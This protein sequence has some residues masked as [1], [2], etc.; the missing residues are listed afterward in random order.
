MKKKHEISLISAT[1][2][3]A[4]CMVGSGW[5]FSSQL[6]AQQAG[7]YS[8]LA[9]VVAA[10]FA[11]IV[12]L[13]F[14][15][16]VQTYPVRG[17]TTRISSLT[18]NSLFGIPFS[19]ANWFGVLVSVATEAQATTQ[20]LASASGS[21][22][23]IKAGDLT[24]LGKGVALS[25]LFLYLVINFYGIKLLARVNNVV[26]FLKVM[27]PTVIIVSFLVV[28][29]T[30]KGAFPVV[31]DHHTFG[32]VLPAVVG[33]GLVYAFNG[34]QTAV[35][36]CSEIKNPTRNVPLS[37][38]LSIFIVLCVYLGLQFAFMEAVRSS[39]LAQGW[40]HLSFNSPLLDLSVILGLH[41]LSLLLVVDSVTSPSG[42]GY[43]YLGASGRM[44]T[45]MAEEGQAPKWLS[46]SNPT[47]NFSRRALLI[48]WGIAAIILYFSTG[49]TALM[50]IVTGLNIIGYLAA[51]I[52]MAAITPK[53]RWAGVIVFLLISLFLSSVGQHGLLL[54]NSTI[55]LLILAYVV[56]HRHYGIKNILI[57]ISP[58]VIYFWC[59]LF[60]FYVIG[61]VSILL[62]FLMSHPKYVTCL[63]KM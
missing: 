63:N 60:P 17:A 37:I 28:A 59:L 18:H 32:N 31:P 52:S 46:V 35:S 26:T 42:T 8:F 5:L 25:I 48:N 51:P 55:T 19:F 53:L 54:I 12:G 14:A 27:T 40:N 15:K 6:V 57:S 21:S 43:S 41:Y 23:F 1:A 13:C 61:V 56:G 30:A 29:Y 2:L 58:V 24:L 20:Y 9:W 38:F 50:L 7:W 44:L 39:L 16:V 36:F 11:L 45:A 62:F 10:V 3:S 49:W 47:Y 34:F 33:A 22:Y 4:S